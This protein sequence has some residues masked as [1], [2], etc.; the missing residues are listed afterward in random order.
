M[1][2]VDTIID[3]KC[4][5]YVRAIVFHSENM[6]DQSYSFIMLISV[7]H[8]SIWLLVWDKTVD[9]LTRINNAKELTKNLNKN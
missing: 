5:R 6:K 2:V 3:N 8:I 1:I 4:L 7:A 9:I